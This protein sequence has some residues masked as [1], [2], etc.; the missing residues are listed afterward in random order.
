MLQFPSS[1]AQDIA[2]LDEITD[3]IATLEHE[4]TLILSLPATIHHL[5]KDIRIHYV[6][7]DNG[8]VISPCKLRA[9]TLSIGL[10]AGTP[11]TIKGVWGCSHSRSQPMSSSM[12]VHITI[13]QWT[14]YVV[15]G[16]DLLP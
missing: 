10:P 3:A 2:R 14:S 9:T 7:I 16:K 1:H 4:R 11:Y 12:R 5:P 15:A 6:Q 8:P 13:D